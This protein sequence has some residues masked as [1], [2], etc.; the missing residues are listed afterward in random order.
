MTDLSMNLKSFFKHSAHN[1]IVVIYIMIYLLFFI[2]F[3][4]C[5]IE[6]KSEHT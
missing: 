5:F 3:I 1:V 4:H 6:I 2:T